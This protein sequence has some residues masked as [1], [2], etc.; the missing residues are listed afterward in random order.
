VGQHLSL[1]APDVAQ[2]VAA[3]KVS[4][5]AAY[6]LVDVLAALVPTITKSRGRFNTS[7][8]AR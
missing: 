3:T 8:L 2:I 6:D 1:P 4:R 7:L 5:S